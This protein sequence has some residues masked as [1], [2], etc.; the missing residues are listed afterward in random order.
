M[1]Y[2]DFY[3]YS[4][5][6]KPEHAQ[7]IKY[8]IA[9]FKITKE[10]ASVIWYKFP[11]ITEYDWAQSVLVVTPIFEMHPRDLGSLSVE[12]ANAL[13]QMTPFTTTRI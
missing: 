13:H 8:S 7:F 6:G 12:I 10:A 11:V 5:P 9:A 2:E 1:N 3:K 4:P